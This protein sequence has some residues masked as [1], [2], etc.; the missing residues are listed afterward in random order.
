[1]LLY[2]NGGMMNIY[3]AKQRV[4]DLEKLVLSKKEFSNIIG[5]SLSTTRVY[6]HRMKKKNLLKVIRGKLIFTENEFVIASQ[7]IEPSYISLHSSLYLNNK[8][9]QVPKKIECV[10]TKNTILENTFEYYKIHPKLFF[11]FKKIRLSGSWAFVA[12]P[13]KALIDGIYLKRIS[14]ELVLELLPV[15]RKNVLKDILLRIK[16]SNVKGTK[17]VIKFFEEVM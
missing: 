7:L 9:M 6:V 1:M 14:E 8:I 5:K 4:I 16:K 11:A 17:R 10:N 3:E 13:E 15:M 2:C 12:E